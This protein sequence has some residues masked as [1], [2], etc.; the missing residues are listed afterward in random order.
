[1]GKC[2]AH[3]G[4]L[5]VNSERER[6][7]TKSRSVNWLLETVELLEKYRWVSDLLIKF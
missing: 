4:Y 6:R 7:E 5:N 3:N 1:M 2:L